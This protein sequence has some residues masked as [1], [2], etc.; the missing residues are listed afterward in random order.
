MPDILSDKKFNRSLTTDPLK[1]LVNWVFASVQVWVEFSLI[2]ADTDFSLAIS[3]DLIRALKTGQVI[4]EANPSL[5]A[6]N[7]QTWPVLRER[8]FG[9]FEGEAASK[10]TDI[11]KTLNK[12][13]LMEWGPS[14][15]ETGQHFRQGELEGGRN[16]HSYLTFMHRLS[17]LLLRIKPILAKTAAELIYHFHCL[18]LPNESCMFS[19]WLW[20]I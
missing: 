10:M 15:G 18:L 3:S 19:N 17:F 6:D 8:C 1:K 9:E 4:A 20:S 2:T 7:I 16:W 5:S 12:S 13:Q 14:G 11:L